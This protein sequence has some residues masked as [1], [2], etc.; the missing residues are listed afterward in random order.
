[1]GHFGMLVQVLNTANCHVAIF[2][3]MFC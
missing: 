3:D 2:H 1:L